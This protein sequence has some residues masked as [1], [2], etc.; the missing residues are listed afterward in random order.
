MHPEKYYLYIAVVTFIINL[1]T[2]LFWSKGGYA[3]IQNFKKRK[4]DKNTEEE[5]VSNNYYDEINLQFLINEYQKSKEN[6]SNYQKILFEKND[7]TSNFEENKEKYIK[8]I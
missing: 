1:L 8:Y 7:E 5:I 4:E 6:E 3:C 2:R